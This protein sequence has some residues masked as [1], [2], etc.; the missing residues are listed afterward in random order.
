MQIALQVP[1]TPLV[2]DIDRQAAEVC[3]ALGITLRNSSRL[4]SI[5]PFGGDVER[6]ADGSHSV[7]TLG[8]KR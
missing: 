6:P 5:T 1:V 8:A 7:P 2:G 4:W 3:D